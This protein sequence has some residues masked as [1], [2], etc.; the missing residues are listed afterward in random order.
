MHKS[1]LFEL[2]YNWLPFLSR[3]LLRVHFRIQK[4]FRKKSKLLKFK[5]FFLISMIW[6]D[7]FC[8]SV[9][10]CIFQSLLFRSSRFN[11]FG[12]FGSFDIL[13]LR[14][15]GFKRAVQIGSTL[16][17]CNHS[18]RVSETFPGP[19]QRTDNASQCTQLIISIQFWQK[20]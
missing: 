19:K 2:L 17:L 6:V 8:C 13:Q 3:L 16:L 1:Q 15:L 14:S 11:C 12:W 5:T 7:E 18:A 4:L 9:W 20:M 10:I